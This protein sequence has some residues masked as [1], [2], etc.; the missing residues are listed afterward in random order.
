MT[1]TAL[2]TRR[3]QALGASL[4]VTLAAVGFAVTPVSA[5]TVPAPAPAG[6]TPSDATGL[7]VGPLDL[8]DGA[9]FSQSNDPHGNEV[10]A[11][12]RAANG[13]LVRVGSFATG[14]TGSGGFEDSANG[15]VLGRSRGEASPNN[16]IQRGNRLFVTNAGSDSISVFKV[17]AG[18]LKLIQVQDSGAAKP[19]S[20]TVNDGIMYVLN[21]NEV[22]DGLITP[23]CAP[24]NQSE[25]PVLTGFTIGKGTLLAPLAGS[26]R[27]LSGNSGCAQVSFN[28]AGTSLV[29]TERTAT[30]DGQAPGDEGVINVFDVEDDGLLGNR[31]VYDATSSGPFGFT[32]TKDGDLLTSEQNDGIEGPGLGSAAG[33]RLSANGTLTPAGPS[34]PNGGTDSCWFVVT[35]NGRY[36]YVSSFFGDGQISSYEV[37]DNANLTLIAGEADG[38]SSHEGA[39]DLA[40]S[41]NSDYLYALNSFAG[42][43]DSYLVES[44]GSLV[45]IDSDAAHAPSTM[46]APMG[47]A[48]S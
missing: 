29:V 12:N 31:K 40:L 4:A 48:A 3:A 10:V 18:R 36:G 38:G 20:L 13:M 43:I 30:I 27:V 19:V 42:T 28:P 44:D 11:F 6:G 16:N 46:A 9:V 8:R 2:R 47:L 7:A 15:V 14:G 25:R 26:T 5:G 1:R 35:D 41:R 21:S 37:A 34:A 32:F 22:K 17:F 33:Y 23:N 24:P 39:S 45:L